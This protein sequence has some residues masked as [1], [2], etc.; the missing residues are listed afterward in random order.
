MYFL[1]TRGVCAR[2]TYDEEQKRLRIWNGWC[3][4]RCECEFFRP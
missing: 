3:H 2:D 1:G 4:L